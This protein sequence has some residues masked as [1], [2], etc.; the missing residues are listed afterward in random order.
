MTLKLTDYFEGLDDSYVC[1][2]YE[3]G[4]VDQFNTSTNWISG[5][6]NTAK[7]SCLFN[8]GTTSI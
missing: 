8:I 5:L 1:S 3:C 6:M 4:E 7:D 2:Y